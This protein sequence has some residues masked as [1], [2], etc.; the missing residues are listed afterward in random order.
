MGI[1]PKPE[2]RQQ[3]VDLVRQGLPDRE[4]VARLGVTKNVV[5]GHRQRAGL[6]S[7][8]DH[9]SNLSKSRHRGLAASQSGPI[10]TL[11]D[12]MAA[13]EAMMDQVMLECGEPQRIRIDTA[14]A[15][16]H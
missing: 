14:S 10:K 3:I 16:P 15:L 8:I 7:N 4:I 13:L 2:L 6:S 12:R 5:I 1:R 9:K 11:F